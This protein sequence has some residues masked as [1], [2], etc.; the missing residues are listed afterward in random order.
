MMRGLVLGLLLVLVAP[1]SLLSCGGDGASSSK[2]GRARLSKKKKKK[3]KAK[4]TVVGGI[5]TSKIPKKLVNVNWKALDQAG[6][7]LQRQGIRDPF[8]PH[9]DDL[10]QPEAKGEPGGEEAEFPVPE[11]VPGLQLIAIITGTAVHKAMVIDSN[12]LGH[13]VRAGEI[14]GKPPMRVAR[15]TRNEVLFQSL[16]PSAEEAD[17]NSNGE[18]RKVLLTQAELEELLP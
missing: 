17:S 1:G 6:L 13:V 15:I 11:A 8:A 16:T 5:D 3:K 18:V 10:L 4:K 2:P 12:G 7:N 14:I 9:V